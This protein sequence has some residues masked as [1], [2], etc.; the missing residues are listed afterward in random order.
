MSRVKKT[1]THIV[2]FSYM[3]K[4]QVIKYNSEYAC[5]DPGHLFRSTQAN[6]GKRR[7][8][9]SQTEFVGITK[10]ATTM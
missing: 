8:S 2:S 10:F 1:P 3:M 5:L 9:R 6:G 4:R 7:Q